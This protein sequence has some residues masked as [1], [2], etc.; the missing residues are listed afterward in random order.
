[1]ESG[2][3]NLKYLIPNGKL[4]KM[5]QAFVAAEGMDFKA[6]MLSIVTPTFYKA[7][8]VSVIKYVFTSPEQLRQLAASIPSCKYV[9]GFN[10]CQTWLLDALSK[11]KQYEID[12]VTYEEHLLN[13][14]FSPVKALVTPTV[15]VVGTIGN[16]ALEGLDTCENTVSELIVGR[17]DRAVSKVA[18]GAGRMTNFAVSGVAGTAN[19]LMDGV[20]G[21]ATNVVGAVTG[22][23]AGQ[24]GVTANWKETAERAESGDIHPVM[25]PLAVIGKTTGAVVNGAARTATG[26]VGDVAGTATGALTNTVGTFTGAVSAVGDTFEEVSRGEL[27]PV[28]GVGVAVGRATV[29]VVEGVGRTAVGA[30]EGIANT[31]VGLVKNIF[32]IF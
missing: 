6:Y 1:L 12:D 15:K 29:A 19:C 7:L 9:A 4:I 25:V 31:G 30:V 11:L 14:L 28:A 17:P 32:S 16:V 23:Y 22:G 13:T 26:L 24:G 20:A 2:F 27:N 3:K 21:V 18:E 8:S 10:D 5:N